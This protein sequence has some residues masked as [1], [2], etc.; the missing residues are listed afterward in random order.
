MIANRDQL[1]AA[2]YTANGMVTVDFEDI[3]IRVDPSGHKFN[4]RSTFRNIEE[5]ADTIASE[6][7]YEPLKVD[8]LSDGSIYLNDGERRHKALQMIRARSSE[9]A[10]R[11][12][13]VKVLVNDKN[14]TD[15]DRLI[16]QITSNSGEPFD[17][18]DEAEAFKELRDG[19]IDGTK[20]TITDIATRTGKSIPYVESRLILADASDEEKTLV[21][22][23]KVSP[24]ALVSLTRLEDSS[25]KRIEAVKDKNSQGKK[26]KV[27]DVR[28]TPV[29]GL[30][31]DV[32][33][34]FKKIDDK[35][36]LSGE[37]GNLMLD[38][39]AKIMAIKKTIQ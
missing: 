32:L 17:I 31:N 34:I 37:L 19:L 22:D 20:L 1:R 2:S 15:T 18:M 29:V 12:S 8:I 10:A 7:L 35:F 26:L 11:F 3:L 33:L 13:K 23:H 28:N 38:A 36:D 4:R 39:R 5:L 21:R 25:E 30:C 9:D 6:G 14:M 27:K 16:Q 24:T